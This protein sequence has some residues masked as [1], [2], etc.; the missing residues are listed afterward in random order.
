M[1]KKQVWFAI[2]AL[3]LLILLFGLHLRIAKAQYHATQLH[4]WLEFFSAKMFKLE[5]ALLYTE[6][7]NLAAAIAETRVEI[8]YLEMILGHHDDRLS[9]LTGTSALRDMPGGNFGKLWLA[10][11]LLQDVIGEDPPADLEVRIQRASEQ[12]TSLNHEMT[13]LLKNS[14]GRSLLI[15]P[16]LSK[17]QK[18]RFNAL[19]E[20]MM[21]VILEC[22]DIQPGQVSTE[23]Y[24]LRPSE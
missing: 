20:D 7:E 15:I 21:A 16:T 6:P 19:L 18:D 9:A 11:G 17:E 3:I 22:G 23:W 13:Q 5:T 8:R 1:S 2:I 10:L 14:E 4:R 12:M 24:F